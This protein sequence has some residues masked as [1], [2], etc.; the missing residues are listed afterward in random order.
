MADAAPDRL[1][2]AVALLFI[3]GWRVSEVLGLAWGDVDLDS[4]VAEV[5]RGC[6]YADGVGMV[7]GPQKT[8]GAIGRHH[9]TP[10]VVEL[11][12]RRRTAQLEERLRAGDGYVRHLGDRPQTTAQASSR[13]LDPALTDRPTQR[14][15]RT[16]TQAAGWAP[17]SAT[18]SRSRG[19]NWVDPRS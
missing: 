8:D 5:R 2:V 9:L 19:I 1:G 3:Q 7:L 16:L 13:L 11:L 14:G 12:R 17:S 18:A 6:A 10:V 4:G 15:R